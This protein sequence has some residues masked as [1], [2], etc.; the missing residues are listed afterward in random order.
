MKKATSVFW[1]AIAG[2]LLLVIW[3]SFAPNNLEQITAMLTE[4]I[5]NK[6]GWYY[7]LLV[8]AIISYCIYLMFSNYGKIKL[9]EENEKPE[10]SL[11]SWFAML[12]SA[13]MGIGVVF[14]STAEPITYAFINPPEAEKGSEQAINEAYNI[15]FYIGALV[16]GLFMGLLVLSLPT[17]NSI[18]DIQD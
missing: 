17:L 9:G 7:L 16:L 2:C 18:K 8:L 12:F 13:G 3:G 10:F 14:W 1:Y 4:F 6:F 11:F 5:S 15:P